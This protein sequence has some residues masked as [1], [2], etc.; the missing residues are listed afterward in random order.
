MSGSQRFDAAYYARFYGRRPVHDGKRIARLAT[1]RLL[2]NP[3][4]VRAL[5]LDRSMPAMRWINHGGEFLGPYVGDE[6][7]PRHDFVAVATATKSLF[8]MWRVFTHSVPHTAHANHLRPIHSK[9]RDRRSASRRQPGDHRCVVAPGEMV[10]PIVLVRMKQR[11]VLVRDWIGGRC[12]IR[13]VSIACRARQAEVLEFGFASRRSRG[14]M[15][16][17]KNRKRQV[18][19]SLT[20]GAPVRKPSA[21][22]P[23]K[24]RGDL[25]GHARDAP[26]W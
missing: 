14:N 16:E 12:T 1:M 21:N 24:I 3:E 8:C 9:N 25:D 10:E 6:V 7:K 4:E 18:L 15:F 11:N 17:F 13:L 26:A 23:L 20:I 19:W 5:L 22:L 2:S